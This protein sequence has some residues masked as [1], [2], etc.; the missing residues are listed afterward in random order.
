[1]SKNIASI[2]LYTG[3]QR[4]VLSPDEDGKFLVP[5]IDSS[6]GSPPLV[7]I[8]ASELI[9][10]PKLKHM[11]PVLTLNDGSKI[12]VFQG[13]DPSGLIIIAASLCDKHDDKYAKIRAEKTNTPKGK[14]IFSSDASGDNLREFMMDWGRNF[15]PDDDWN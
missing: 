2:S 1:M 6:S 15:N 14:I 7:K 8:N 9:S 3:G 10:H 12:R 11:D 5:N 13:G 4:V